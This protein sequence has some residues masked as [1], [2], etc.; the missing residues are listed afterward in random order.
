MLRPRYLLIFVLTAFL[1]T[2]GKAGEMDPELQA[3]ISGRSPSEKISVWIE[4]VPVRD[5]RSFRAEMQA[6]SPSRQERH[7]LAVETL[8]REHGNS[9]KNLVAHLKQMQ[10]RGEATK[11]RPRWIANL[12][13]AEVSIGQLRG[14]ANR[15]DVEMIYPVP[16]LRLIEPEQPQLS[17]EAPDTLPNN[18]KVIR[19]DDAWAAGY[20]GAGRLICTFDT[21]IEGDHPA[22]ADRWKGLDGDW[23]AAWLD[24]TGGS[25]FPQ[26][27]VGGTGHG[28]HVL[29]IALGH[30]DTA[31]ET[32]GVAL[33]ARWISAAVIDLPAAPILDAFEWAADPDGDPNTIDDVPDVINHSWGV[34]GIGCTNVFYAMID[35]TEALGIVNVFS[36]GNDGSTSMSIRNPANRALDSLDCF[37]I[38]N[39]STLV[40]PPVIAG[41]SSRGPSDC[42]GA[43]KP[44]VCA[45]GTA[46]WSVRA[47]S[48]YTSMSGTSM[49]AP[50]VSGLVAL[51]RQKNPDATVDQV[52]TAILNTAADF[53]YAL[54]DNTYGW[55][56]IDCMAALNALPAVSGPLLRVHGFAHDPILP[57][58][59]VTGPVTLQNFG[60]IAFSVGATITGSNPALRVL[61]GSLSFGTIF[62]GST[63]Q[64]GD[65]VS[66]VVSDT[67][68]AGRM[69][70]LD[71]TITGSGY[72]RTE[73]LFFAVG[74]ALERQ[75]VDHNANRITF[76]VTNYGFFGLAPGSW[77]PYG[78]SGFRTDGGSNQIFEAALLMGFSS[79]NI[80]DGARAA[81]GEPDGD[82][83]VA[84]G[85]NLQL[86]EP[87][88]VAAEETVS[89]FT[90]ERA[91]YPMNVRVNQH[92]YAFTE[93][94]YDNF[95]IMRY[96]IHNPNEYSIANF[97]VGLYFD[98]DVPSAASYM[99][100]AGGWNST[101][102]IGWIG[103]NNAGTFS[104]FR[105]VKILSG[106]AGSAF[107][108]YAP[109]FTYYDYEGGDGFTEGE[110][111]LALTSGFTTGNTYATA[112]LDLM[113]VV[114]AAPFTLVA[115]GTDTVA[116]GIVTGS[117]WSEFALAGARASEKYDEISA[118]CCIGIR[119]NADGD[120]E[121]RINVADITYL[122]NYLFKAGPLPPCPEEANI[123]ADALEKLN[124][125]DVT[126]VIGY[127]FKGGAAPLDCSVFAP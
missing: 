118:G 65:V 18:L 49:S 123:D 62:G 90:D 92:T 72:S 53:G 11:I 63:V 86:L 101:D 14:L 79:G 22:Y 114:S 96:I 113:Q 100:N 56:I 95:L 29:G 8:K 45:P 74:P 57:G 120:F 125:A 39:V 64:S 9:Q 127:L 94:G 5:S 117:S 68:T 73:K 58:D 55:G 3:Q 105:G 108:G 37:A 107:T 102:S 36:A 60:T 66:V 51:L 35:N 41:S 10:S 20:T 82:F 69:I 110:K 89:Q 47:D 19:A 4:L 111:Y 115:G 6:A 27:P 30:D 77:V 59:T 7:R 116:F 103:W 33:D 21:G 40:S 106:P 70:P 80:S 112:S 17:P 2:T 54:P 44:N 122:I 16:T 1:A 81:S 24:A 98:W 15:P 91:E 83:S 67:V 34:E 75:K 88:P 93:P 104:T 84:P 25:T 32:T 126:Y 85:G 50:H 61:D 76:T 97:R 38:G 99:D 23:A 87:G 52:K 31:G 43:R 78:G 119:G 26:I 28:S 13:E 71:L 48:G 12:V 124:V 42:N 109:E 121:D 46:I